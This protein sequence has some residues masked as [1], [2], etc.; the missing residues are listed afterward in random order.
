MKIIY[1]MHALKKFADLASYGIKVRKAKIPSTIRKPKYK[2]RDNDNTISV[3]EFD[4]QHNIRVVHKSENH[5]IIIITFYIYR[6]GR[7]GEY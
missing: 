3:S 4:R 1:T 5:D 7:Y 6:K 2:S